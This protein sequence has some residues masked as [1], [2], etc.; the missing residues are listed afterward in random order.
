M[1]SFQLHNVFL[2]K[3]RNKRLLYNFYYFGVNIRKFS[4]SEFSYGKY[5]YID[6]KNISMM[7]FKVIYDLKKF[8]LFNIFVY[9]VD[10]KLKIK[11]KR[12]D[13]NFLFM[14]YFS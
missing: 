11:I 1:K 8:I 7:I 6:I 5:N 10:E 9:Y 14:L 12:C 3:Y 4:I 2:Y 13:P